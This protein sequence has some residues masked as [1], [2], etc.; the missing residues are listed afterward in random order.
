MVSEERSSFEI[1]ETY[2]PAGSRDVLELI[3]RAGAGGIKI[4][5]RIIVVDLSLD[6]LEKL[7]DKVKNGKKS[8]LKC[9]KSKLRFKKSSVSITRDRTYNRIGKFNSIG[10]IN[11][12]IAYL[13]LPIVAPVEV[14][15]QPQKIG[16]ES[17]PYSSVSTIDPAATSTDTS[18]SS[19]ETPDQTAESSQEVPDQTVESSQQSSDESDE[20]WGSA[21]PSGQKS[22]ISLEN[23]KALVEIKNQFHELNKM[24]EDIIADFQTE[25]SE[26]EKKDRGIHLPLKLSQMASDVVHEISIA[27]SIVAS[28]IQETV[29]EVAEGVA[30]V[31]EEIEQKIE[32][33]QSEGEQESEDESG[34]PANSEDQTDTPATSDT[35][36]VV[37][38]IDS[39]G[40]P[41]VPVAIPDVPDASPVVPD[42]VVVPDAS[43][44]VVPDAVVAPVVVPDAVVAPVVVPD[45]SPVSS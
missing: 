4:R 28:E 21:S 10:F 11:A 3:I 44:V 7:L 43:P 24:A 41:D 32:E 13:A 38:A 15:Q 30:E 39:S 22:K 37:P 1:K 6:L 42:A 33:S 14:P 36:I 35:P 34:D 8:I 26:E 17:S 20:S 16:S 19:Q 18:E 5:T 40:S 9:D 25:S 12:L 23:D 2:S 27:A 45:A 29:S 31:L